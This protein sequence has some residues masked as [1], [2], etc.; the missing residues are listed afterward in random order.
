MI[1]IFGAAAV[2]SSFWARAQSQIPGTIDQTFNAGV[3]DGAVRGIALDSDFQ[4]SD[5]RRLQSRRR[6]RPAARGA[7]QFR[8]F[9]G[10]LICSGA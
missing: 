7:A 8:R 10:Q 5:R 3:I 2:L 6:Y 9:G 4:D 1:F